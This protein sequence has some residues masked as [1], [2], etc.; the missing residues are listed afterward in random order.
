MSNY[1]IFTDAN[2]DMDAVMVEKTGVEV[3]PM[4]FSIAGKEY[5]N[6][7]DKRE[8]TSQEF[9][10]L[11]RSG[12]MSSTTQT[13]AIEFEDLFRPFLE[14]GTDVLYIGFSSGLSGTLNASRMAA[15]ALAAE[16]PNARVHI[17]D[18][19]S[20]TYGQTLLVMKAAEMKRAGCSLEEV[21][22]WV[23][24]NKLKTA[25]WFTVDDLNFLKRGGRLSGTAAL[26]GTMLSMKP[27]LKLNDE[28]KIVAV[29]KIR[30]RKN[31][32]NR[33]IDELEKTI[34]TTLGS[35]VYVAHADCGQE[36]E[37]VAA[38]ISRRLPSV[39]A[40]CCYIG[41]VLG[42]HCGPNTIALL[43]F[44]GNRG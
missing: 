38:E 31:S 13:N 9:Y 30:G 3:L 29:D 24:Q 37:E 28:G 25:H 26:F 43:F 40:E 27:V 36:A 44:A 22:A 4:R 6:W 21:A 14:Q 5:Y 23:E 42:G 18:T 32:L 12:E 39:T 34:D 20:I 41:P 1:V 10:R 35:T 15:E 16:F 19:L 7:P 17:V 2:S 33:L 11:I 8:M